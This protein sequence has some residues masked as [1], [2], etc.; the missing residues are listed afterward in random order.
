MSDAPE[1]EEEQLLSV[2]Q[3]REEDGL[4]I[5]RV[6]TEALLATGFDAPDAER[7][8]DLADV[9]YYREP[10]RGAWVATLPDGRVVGCAA[11]D[12]GDGELALLRR[13]AGRGLRP[14]TRT[15]VAFADGRGYRGIEIVLPTAMR[16]ARSAVAGEGFTPAG[17]RNDLLFR[18]SLQLD[19]G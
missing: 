18:R 8:A 7:D 13:L 19:R 10:G 11:L 15:A 1:A 3:A 9:A 2:R 16:D 6:V 12:R 4:E 5:R 14:L 17:P